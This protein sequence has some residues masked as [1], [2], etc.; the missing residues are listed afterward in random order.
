MPYTPLNFGSRAPNDGE[1]FLTAFSKVDTMLAEIFGV[2]GQPIVYP[3]L[4]TSLA[5]LTGVGLI[6]RTAEG[7]AGTVPL[8]SL[9]ESLIGASS[10]AA[11]RAALQLGAAALLGTSG[12][13]SVLVR[14]PDGKLPPG[15]LPAQSVLDV[16]DAATEI[17]MLALDAQK[18]DICLRPA[19]DPAK[20]GYIEVYMLQGT[21]DPTVLGNWRLLTEWG[22][23][24]VASVFG[25]R[26]IVKIDQ[27]PQAPG[28]I[29]DGDAL[30]IQSAATG[31]HHRISRGALVA[32]LAG[33][34]T[35]DVISGLAV[36]GTAAAPTLTLTGLRL[37][38]GNGQVTAGSA[39]LFAY[40]TNTGAPF[41]LPLTG[42]IGALPPR[43]TVLE[44][45]QV[46]LATPGGMFKAPVGALLAGRRFDRPVLAGA[47]QAVAPVAEI[48]G[49]LA[50][51]PS[52]VPRVYW[53]RLIGPVTL[54]LPPR[55]TGPD[56][57]G[58][59]ELILDQD[60]TGGRTLIIQPPSGENLRWHNGIAQSICLTPGGR[61]RLTLQALAGDTRWDVAITHKDE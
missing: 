42:L 56:V 55:P 61:T 20:V 37:P 53:F 22:P 47:V 6:R 3:P 17:E 32:G 59:I 13:G 4:L 21:G 1:S 18:G 28:A 16:L 60:S 43:E 35:A 25:L 44:T 8:T 52:A 31:Q 9:G 14:G 7:L 15:D 30:V 12:A 50:L 49:A 26:G 46:A 51:D 45:D 34:I 39:G 40:D 54:V 27:L 5:A 48:S 36:G 19:T 24:S 58:E 29:A 41:R 38:D 10:P 57:Q 33:S 11:L 2:L 23:E